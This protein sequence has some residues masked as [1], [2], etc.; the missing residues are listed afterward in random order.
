MKLV[1][2]LSLVISV[3]LGFNL[4]QYYQIAN[5]DYINKILEAQNGLYNL[6]DWE[7]DSSG[8]GG[9]YT[10]EQVIEARQA[11]KLD[12]KIEAILLMSNSTKMTEEQTDA[13]IQL[14]TDYKKENLENNSSFLSLLSQ[15]SFHKGLH[16][17]LE[18]A[19]NMA[20]A[21]YERGYHKALEDAACPAT[22]DMKVKKKDIEV[23]K[24]PPPSK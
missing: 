7:R 22:G 16:S 12:G 18:Q 5:L 23:E 4:A 21:E 2:W 11:G 10:T 8:K 1:H 20:N 17:G 14:A 19:E 6:E 9:A 3:S 13:V 24:K 15:A